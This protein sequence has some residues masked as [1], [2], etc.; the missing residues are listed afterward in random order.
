MHFVTVL[1]WSTHALDWLSVQIIKK[2]G[3]VTY[4]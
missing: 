2:K 4:V 1:Q 3:K